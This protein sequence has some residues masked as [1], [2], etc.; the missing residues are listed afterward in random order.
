VLCVRGVELEGV[1]EE[2]GVRWMTL[3]AGHESQTATALLY[4]TGVCACAFVLLLLICSC[5]LT[6]KGVKN[7]C[8]AA[9]TSVGY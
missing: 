2:E 5:E 8:G 1:E 7:T 9:A 6:L 3:G 4:D